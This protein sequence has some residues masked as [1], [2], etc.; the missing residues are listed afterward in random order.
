MAQEILYKENGKE[1]LEYN[2]SDR[3]RKKEGVHHRQ[4][5]AY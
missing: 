4:R 2:V 5:R 3:E 1:N